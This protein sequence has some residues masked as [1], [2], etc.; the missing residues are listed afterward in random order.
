MNQTANEN[1]DAPFVEKKSEERGFA[2]FKTDNK[3]MNMSFISSKDAQVVDSHISFLNKNEKAVV[4]IIV[5]FLIGFLVIFVLVI[6][7]LSIHFRI[8]NRE[9]GPS[10]QGNEL[11]ETGTQPESGPDTGE[12]LM[13]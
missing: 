7:G 4:P 13:A 5:Y 6:V 3:Q 2:V 8:K 12:P 10:T 1:N 9:S 11:N